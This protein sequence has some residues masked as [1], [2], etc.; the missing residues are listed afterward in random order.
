MQNLLGESKL[1]NH[2]SHSKSAE[3]FFL[4]CKHKEIFYFQKCGNVG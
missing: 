3:Q 2:F 4:Y 1:Q